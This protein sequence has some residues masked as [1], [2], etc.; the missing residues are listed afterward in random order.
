MLF[1]KQEEVWQV[2]CG[3][4]VGSLFFFLSPVYIIVSYIGF[5][6]Q[7]VGVVTL[8]TIAVRHAGSV[9][10][11]YWSPDINTPHDTCH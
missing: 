5:Q 7:V 11:F 8:I 2:S 6:S 3:G 4:V 9:V 10:C 1:C